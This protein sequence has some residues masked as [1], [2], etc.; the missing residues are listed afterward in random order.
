MALALAQHPPQRFNP[1]EARHA[2]TTF[3]QTMI[4]KGIVVMVLPK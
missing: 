2:V 3:L 4:K 1:D